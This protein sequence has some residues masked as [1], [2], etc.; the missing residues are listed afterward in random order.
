M[1]LRPDYFPFV[2]TSSVTGTSDAPQV[3]HTPIPKGVSYPVSSPQ[4]RITPTHPNPT[5]QTEGCNTPGVTTL[6]L[7]KALHLSPKEVRARRLGVHTSEET[8]SCI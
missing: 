2:C 8:E 6:R 4:T 3:L 7:P 1:G 5:G